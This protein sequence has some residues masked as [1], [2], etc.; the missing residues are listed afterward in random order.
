MQTNSIQDSPKRVTPE[1]VP[2]NAL[3]VAYKK[4]DGTTWRGFVHP[5]GETTEGD[6]K[7]EVIKKLHEL[8]D[9]YYDILEK[10]DFPAHLKNAGLVELEDRVVFG[11]V[12]ENKIFMDGIHSEEGK[13]DS[14][15]CYV[16]TYWG[17]P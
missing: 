11:S 6:S 3:L 9:A 7:K 4:D 10:Y 14:V 15:N 1:V 5:Y 12:V 16:E 17:K 8:A 2:F 13:A